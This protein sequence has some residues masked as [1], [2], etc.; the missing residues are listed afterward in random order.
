M[1]ASGTTYLEISRYARL[2][3]LSIANVE[4]LSATKC[5]A[6]GTA[7][8]VESAWELGF[9]ITT[10]IYREAI[11]R[12]FADLYGVAR[13]EVD[14]SWNKDGDNITVRCADRTF[15]HETIHDDDDGTLE[16][17]SIHDDPVTVTLTNDERLRL[18]NLDRLNG[19]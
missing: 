3:T 7:T 8:S 15:T 2:F 4:P 11:K 12:A 18:T 6:P 17:V 16:F 19:F 10:D 1:D 14:V 5:W 9:M 13:Q